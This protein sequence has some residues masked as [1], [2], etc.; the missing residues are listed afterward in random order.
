MATEILAIE[1]EDLQQVIDIIRAG[2]GT[3]EGT[4][5]V[6]RILERW[7]KAEDKYLIELKKP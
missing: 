2:I 3:G 1:E 6:H 5:R 7:C 4:Q